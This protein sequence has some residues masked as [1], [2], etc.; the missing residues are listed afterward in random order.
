[1]KRL[2]LLF[3]FIFSSA[4]SARV[5]ITSVT[6]ASVTSTLGIPGQSV[7]IYGGFGGTSCG[8]DPVATCDSCA[9]CG[10]TLCV[11][12]SHRLNNS[13]QITI[14][15]ISDSTDAGRFITITNANN[16]PNIGSNIPYTGAGATQTITTTWGQLCTA[17]LTTSAGSTGTDCDSGT[18]VNNVP[19]RIG[20]TDGTTMYDS[21]IITIW[22]LAPV[23]TSATIDDCSGA[24][25][26]GAGAICNFRALPG[27]ASIYLGDVR[28]DANWPGTTTGVRAYISDASFTAAAPGTALTSQDFSLDASGSLNGAIIT[29]LQNDGPIYHIRLAALDA[30]G[31]VYG[32]L[33]DTNIQD[34][35]FG[36]CPAPGDFPTVTDSTDACRYKAMPDPVLGL[37]SK[38]MNC[39]IA[40]AAYGSSLEPKINTFRHFRNE[41]LIYN[42]LGRKFVYGYYHYGPYAARWIADRDWARTVARAGLWPLWAFANLSLKIG[43]E[44]A[45]VVTLMLLIG[46]A[47]LIAA[48]TSWIRTP[49]AKS[50]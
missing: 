15:F 25:D 1:M 12:N 26:S 23:S 35:N 19:L 33:S 37:L 31:N 39:F 50:S 30:T 16:I 10:G 9:S 22:A 27:D 5:T 21:G 44:R 41:F 20:L 45:V 40:T 14:T 34:V 2:S 17:A 6:G 18:A 13:T 7:A 28:G 49:R 48:L 36:N 11:C 46:L 24:N 47:A 29:G 4:A 42:R 43:L 8:T 38:D 3:F 32:F